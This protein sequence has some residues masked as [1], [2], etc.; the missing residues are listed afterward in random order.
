MKPVVVLAAAAICFMSLNASA[1]QRPRTLKDENRHIRK[2]VKS[3]EL[4]GRE[5]VQL[6]RQEQKLRKE[7]AR[8]EANDG[9]LSRR[10]K[11]KLLRD[12]KKLDRNIRRQKHDRQKRH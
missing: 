6:K 10:E 1:Q 9:T 11:G 7:K 12:E 5:T 3:G 4:T 8:F 2:G